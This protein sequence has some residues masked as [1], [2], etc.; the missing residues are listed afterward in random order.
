MFVEKCKELFLSSRKTP[1]NFKTIK[2]LFQPTKIGE[3]E[4][5]LARTIS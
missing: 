4:T 3:K 2:F 1:V 5:V